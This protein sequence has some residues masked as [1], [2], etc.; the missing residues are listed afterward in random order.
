VGDAENRWQVAGS[1]YINTTGEHEIEETPIP[2]PRTKL[3]TR[4]NDSYDRWEKFSRRHGWIA[5]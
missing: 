1:T 4:W 3:P 2:A 5:A